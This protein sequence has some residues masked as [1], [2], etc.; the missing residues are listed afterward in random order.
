MNSTKGIIDTRKG[1]TLG[2]VTAGSDVLRHK[3]SMIFGN[4][5]S[6]A[7]WGIGSGIS[8]YVVSVFASTS[9]M[10]R[11]HVYSYALAKF[12]SFM[13][14]PGAINV[15]T[16]HG[17]YRVSAHEAI[18]ALGDPMQRILD[19]VVGGVWL[20]GLVSAVV[21]GWFVVQSRVI[22]ATMK[23]ATHNRGATVVD[24]ADL[25]DIV[26]D[27]AKAA[28]RPEIEAGK[29]FLMR[30]VAPSW[31][32]EKW[33]TDRIRALP[34]QASNVHI[35]ET[36]LPPGMEMYNQ[37]LVGVIGTGKSVAIKR[38]L[39][40]IAAKGGRCVVYDPTGEFVRYFYDEARGDVILNPIID[41]RSPTW[42]PWN[43]I[44][45]PAVDINNLAKGL[46]PDP[47]AGTDGF[48]QSASQQLFINIIEGLTT[49][50][51][52][53][54]E[55]AWTRAR[56][57]AL[58]TWPGTW[59]REQVSDT[60]GWTYSVATNSFT[61]AKQPGLVLPVP[62]M[63]DDRYPSR[64]AAEFNK[65]PSAFEL[66]ETAS[67]MALLD[68]MD[69]EDKTKVLVPGLVSLVKGTSS[70][71]FI[72]DKAEKTGLSVLST[73]V[74]A[75]E[76]LKH[77]P[78][79][80]EQFSIRDW[81]QRDD[82]SWLFLLSRADVIE[83]MKPLISLWLDIAIRQFML[84]DPTVR[85]A[86]YW[87]ICDELHSLGKISSLQTSMTQA[88]KYGVSHLLGF[89]T[90]GQLN[91]LYGK[92][93][94]ETLLTNCQTTMVLRC[95]GENAKHW[96][97]VLGDEEVYEQSMGLSYG[98][99]S[100]RDGGSVNQARV[101]KR[102]VMPSEISTLPNLHGFLRLPG[103]YPVARVTLQIRNYEE[104]APDYVPR[105]AVP[106][107]TK[108]ELAA[109]AGIL[110]AAAAKAAMETEVVEAIVVE[111]EKVEHIDA[112]T[113][114]ITMVDIEST[115][116]AIPVEMARSAPIRKSLFD[117]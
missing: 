24:E 115:P 15:T 16:T 93:A 9:A 50:K 33:V 40:D 35:G 19:G 31:Y 110:K 60:T 63:P 34:S 77:V 68:E 61:T 75:L 91:E 48:W 64:T 116:I 2:G 78:N 73:M 41:A 70:S 4:V 28:K 88:R 8:T 105:T 59:F 89:Q 3:I 101:Q 18:T 84:G 98:A 107:K 102:I 7:S 72:N 58:R 104:K 55:A 26:E 20:P 38:E 94:A 65:T 22:A 87:L 74:T 23:N 66:F 6:V 97:E 85:S 86:K 71:R 100:M 99:D 5:G 113:G 112:D 81:V 83:S 13:H 51:A 95:S 67:S 69:P 82:Q 109:K 43:E 36:P 92:E 54:N 57:D 52:I 53:E 103:D 62:V 114:E 117:D 10:D 106:Q 76:Q 27:R 21:V 14:L 17:N 39:S 90:K 111:A 80:G 25:I 30:H 37:A 108:S 44:R 96:S 29:S 46:I 42:S 11:S 32:Q 1:P 12:H 56:A 49:D 47:A 79:V 45:N